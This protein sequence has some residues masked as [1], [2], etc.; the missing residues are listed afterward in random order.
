[1]SFSRALNAKALG[2][3]VTRRKDVVKVIEVNKLRFI[4]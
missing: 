2:R 4:S 3:G 1:M